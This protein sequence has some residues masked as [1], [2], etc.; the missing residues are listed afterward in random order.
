MTLQGLPTDKWCSRMKEGTC[1]DLPLRDHQAEY[2]LR[3]GHP[4]HP[5]SPLRT[6]T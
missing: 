4:Y 2:E 1:V 5:V 6:K 3:G